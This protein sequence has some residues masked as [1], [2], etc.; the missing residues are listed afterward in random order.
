MTQTNTQSTTLPLTH[1]QRLMWIG[2]RVHPDVPIYNMVFTFTFQ[3]QIDTE[4][5]KAAFA[6][7]GEACASLRTVIREIDGEP[8]QV[9]LPSLPQALEIIDLTSE[10]DGQVA[11]SRWVDERRTRTLPLE[12]CLYDSALIRVSESQFVWYLN[13]HHLIT[14]VTASELIYRLMS[15]LYE[16]A[17]RDEPLS[18]PSLPSYADY[19]A[20]EQEVRTGS[21]FAAAKAYWQE[22]L[23]QPIDLVS[24]YGE[25]GSTHLARTERTPFLISPEQTARLNEL[26]TQPGFRSFTRDMTFANLY[27]ALVFAYLHRL[28][29][30]T[31]IRLGIPLANRS[32]P[33]FRET[34]AMFIEVLSL[35]IRFDPD[36][37]FASL[38]RKVAAAN[39]RTLQNLQPGIASAE[40]HHAYNML[41]NFITVSF[42]PFAGIPTRAEW[43][44]SGYGDSTDSIRFQVHDL[45]RTG[46]TSIELDFNTYLHSDVERQGLL[47]QFGRVLDACLRDP[48][49]PIHRISLLTDVEY[50]HNIVQFN[51]TRKPYPADQTVIDLFEA[52]AARAPDATA[53]ALGTTTLSY[54]QLKRR[55]DA[56]M[57]TLLDLGA[58]PETLIP[59]CME[60]SIE[61]VVALLAILKAGCAYIPIDPATPAE[62]IASLLEDLGK[63][64]IAV[65]DESLAGRFSSVGCVA[66]PADVDDRLLPAVNEAS[67]AQPSQCAYLI[68]TSGTT[69]KPKGVMVQHNNLTSYLWWAKRMYADHEPTTFALYSSL[70]F[71]LTV[72]SVFVPLISGGTIRV[73]PDREKNGLLIREVFRDNAVDVV[74]LTP[75]H[76]ALVRD[77]DLAQTR[78]KQLIVGGEDFKTE[79][80]QA[81]HRKSNGQIAQ[82]NEYGPTESTV[83]CM[84]HT[85]DPRLDTRPSVPIGTPSDNM[86]VYILDKR[87]QPTPT[88]MIGE[89]YLSGANIARGY[90][91]RPELTAE[92][93]L[94]DPF[95]PG[96]RMYRTGDLARWL[97][98]GHLEF[99]G[100]NDHQVKV[101][102]ARIELGEVEA[103]LLSHHEITA[104]A[105][106]VRRVRQAAAPA[107]EE[108][109]NHC[110]RCG[111]ASNFPGITFDEDGVCSVCLRYDSYRAKAQAYF[112]SMDALKE[113]VE[114]IKARRA[115]EYDCIVLFSGGKDSA[116]MLFQLVE[117]GLR[118]L[119]F[120]LDNGYISDDAKANIRR[121]TGSLGV[122]HVFATTP[123][124]NAIFVDSLH[125]FANVCNGCFK[126]IYT[127]AID[128]ARQKGIRVIVTG[129]SRGQ[130]FETRLTEELFVRD[131]FDIQAIDESIARARRAYHQRDD[132]ISRS[133]EVDVFRDQMLDEIEF[134]DFY[135]YCDVALDEMYRYLTARG[136]TRP[137]DTGRSTNCL[138]NDVGIYV[139]KQRRGFHNYALPYSWDVR[140][141]HKTRDQAIEELNDEID[142]HRVKRILH[143]IGYEDAVDTE[144]GA[145]RLVAY[146]TSPKP[147][148]NAEVR[149][150]LS[151]KLTN[152]MVPS[153][154]IWLET[155]PLAPSGKVNRAALPDIDDSRPMSGSTL[156][157]PSNDV[158]EAIHRIWQEVLLL[159]TISIYDNFFDLGGHSLPAIRIVSRINSMFDIDMP[160][161]TFFAHPT[162]AQL[163]VAVDEIL[164]AEI[165]ALSD[166]EA[167]QLLSGD[168]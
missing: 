146:Y 93:F 11:L 20:H 135:R 26:A 143:E 112:K 30:N 37:T 162:I 74:K 139:H 92:R 85:Y 110:T 45:N 127:L 148:P 17:L 100:R 115:G 125:H 159:Q 24:L 29:G 101:G 82:H 39:V 124:M 35:H 140:M 66:R 84:I 133:L 96:Q 6:I 117:M 155:M 137:Q 108:A 7:L 107:T 59:V 1:S 134:V 160:I 168:G 8:M 126:A 53:V 97:P 42:A 151:K 71:D 67:L 141:G 56:F 16:Q 70:A 149:D 9:I 73:Y 51:D 60:T 78:V 44:H 138:I 54:H 104:V 50:Q 2:Q 81:I 114:R 57:R 129:L 4:A 94:D 130:F 163:A 38:V 99:L 15:R 111:L 105:V 18:V 106:D 23:S 36:E 14:D 68:F 136:W 55:V 27:A 77:L 132:L 41:L 158:E 128:L 131:D 19:V 164:I 153:H 32:T 40:H 83:A 13:Q 154:F 62:R 86:Q 75:S 48:Q 90:L 120:T 147:I 31:D 150:H 156:V 46:Q 98:S 69:G 103:A 109:L 88:G 118:V 61:V 33:A 3:S 157:A 43:V 49:Q 161:D 165:E 10:V 5:F 52:Q 119:S 152:F 144:A 58:E 22:Y 72:T 89:M 80:A 21:A 113:I 28:S 34:I 167:R 116:F 25:S 95:T 145:T 12:S 122:D 87:L 166:E 65:V 47:D 91:N 102:G 79:L 76:L 121:I 63:T 123:F 142:S 64:P